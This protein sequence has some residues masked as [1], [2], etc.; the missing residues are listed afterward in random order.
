VGGPPGLSQLRH[1]DGEEAMT[2][3]WVIIED[4][5]TPGLTSREYNLEEMVIAN[6]EMS[7][8]DLGF[9]IKSMMSMSM[10]NIERFGGRSVH[11]VWIRRTR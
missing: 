10:K 2:K 4:I 8:A 9:L 11:S 3:R 6:I 7:S 1:Q 5:K